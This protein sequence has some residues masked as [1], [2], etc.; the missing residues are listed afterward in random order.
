LGG[1][2]IL[3][4]PRCSSKVLFELVTKIFALQSIVWEP[5]HHVETFAGER[6]V[7][8]AEEKASQSPLQATPDNPK[9]ETLNPIPIP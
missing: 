1:R 7:T 9:P 5:L 4:T 6:A 3:A 2:A 8:L